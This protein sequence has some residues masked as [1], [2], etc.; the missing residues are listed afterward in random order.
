[1]LAYQSV[2]RWWLQPIKQKYYEYPGKSSSNGGLMVIYDGITLITNKRCKD[3]HRQKSW[4]RHTMTAGK[5]NISALKKG[6]LP[7][8]G[9]WGKLA[10]ICLS[11]I[12]KP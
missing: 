6:Q 7:G 3:S 10:Y 9:L 5:L 11:K 4:K 8:D 12:P 1:M 2:T